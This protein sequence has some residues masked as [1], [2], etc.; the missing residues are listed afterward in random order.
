MNAPSNPTA[1][2]S[3]FSVARYKGP[4]TSVGLARPGSPLAAQGK[5]PLAFMGLGLA[6]LGVATTMLLAHSEI[7]A[8]S[9]ASP[10]VVALA[11]AW[12]LGVFVTVGTGAIYQIA[13]VALG[14]SLWSER[15]G[16]WHFGLQAV[17]VPGMVFAFSRW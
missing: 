6:W 1:A 5:L 7:L 10:E 8:Q 9:H 13:P 11:H 16:W 3:P 12:I 17:S 4:V 14:A 2:G 15:C